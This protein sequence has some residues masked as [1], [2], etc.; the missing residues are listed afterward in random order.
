MKKAFARK[1]VAF[2]KLNFIILLGFI[3]CPAYLRSQENRNVSPDTLKNQLVDDD[4]RA[5]HLVQ[6]EGEALNSLLAPLSANS[7]SLQIQKNPAYHGYTPQ[8]LVEEIFIKKGGCALV[9]NV[10]YKGHG[11]NGTQWYTY[12]FD[13]DLGWVSEYD[14]LWNRGL[15]YFS[16]TN[17][18]FGMTE[19]LVLSTGDL[20]S[21][22][23][24]V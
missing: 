15:G 23:G 8:Q 21:L 14:N 16:N 10:S 6:Q 24:P 11:W 18:K 17:P 1:R 13:D 12:R 3:I 2:H 5:E 22:E 4:S 7:N 20:F 9:E 19:G